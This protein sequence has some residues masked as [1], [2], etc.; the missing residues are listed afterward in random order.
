MAE[1]LYRKDRIMFV[2]GHYEG[3]DE[4]VY[5]RA[6]RCISLGDYVLTG[7]ELAALTVTDAVVRLIPGVLGDDQ[8][9]VDES[10]GAGLLEY[11]QYT[12]L[13]RRMGWK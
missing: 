10:F 1:E 8:G 5:S 13:L 2:S 12:T 9:C 4:R 3:M 11:A 6:D 7:G